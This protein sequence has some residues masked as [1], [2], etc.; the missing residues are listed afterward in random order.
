MDSVTKFPQF[1]DRAAELGMKAIA[2]TEHGNIY[3]WYSKMMYAREKGL[4]FIHGVEAYVT[5]TLD[6]KIRDNYHVVL[7]AKNTQGFYEI[8]QLSSAASN[9]SDGNRFYYRPRISFEELISTSKN[10]FVLTA[11]IGGILNSGDE[12]L[13]ERMIRF[14]CANKERCFLELQPH[15]VLDQAEYNKKLFD[16][17]ERYG[18]GVVATTDVH[19]LDDFAMEARDVIQKA[20]NTK[21]ENEDGWSLTF[22]SE[23]EMRSMFQKQGALRQAVVDLA[24]QTTG[25]I[26]D[27]VEEIELDYSI[28]YPQ[29]YDNPDE[30]LRELA[31]KAIDTHPD[32]LTFNTR[33]EVK[34]R[35]DYELE[36]FTAIGAAPF[37]L[38]EKNKVDWEH[39]HGIFAGPGRGSAAGCMVAYL[40]G[41][42]D[43]NPLRFDLSFDRFMN[44]DRVTLAD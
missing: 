2:C 21:F 40:F 15:C 12:E 38:L 4:K 24:I 26:A 16:L 10:I 31:Y 7:L 8:N 33:D 18:I 14:M 5:K 22:K 35:V 6:E 41:I 28:K 30:L 29:I 1:V 20:K 19:V 39:E 36:T 32:A 13:E 37:M 23:E 11:C 44:R 3:H 34:A 9:K 25:N 27:Q 42:V 43:V 17:H